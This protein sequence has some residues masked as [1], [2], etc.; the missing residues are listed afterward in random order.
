MKDLHTESYITC[1]VRQCLA[2]WISVCTSGENQ[3]FF[4]TAQTTKEQGHGMVLG[5]GPQGAKMNNDAR[6][7]RRSFYVSTE[8]RE[9]D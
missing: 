8:Q 1:L 2:T 3:V 4:A 9:E 5:K 6:Y 7:V